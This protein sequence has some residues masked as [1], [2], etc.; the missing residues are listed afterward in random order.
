MARSA[1]ARSQ[2]FL[3]SGTLPTD[4]WA[5]VAAFG[6]YFCMYMFRKPYTAAS[7]ESMRAFE[8]A[9]KPLAIVSQVLGYTISKFVGIRVVAEATPA[10]RIALYLGLIGSAELALVLF[11]IT[12][13][14]WNLIWLFANGLPLGMVFGLVLPFLEGRTRTELLTAGLCASFVLADGVAKSVGVWLMGQGVAET[15]MPATSGLIFVPGILLFGWML[16]K[17]PPPSA[18][19]EQQRGKREPMDKAMRCA[20][21]RKF[22][23]G[24]GLLVAVYS[25]VGVL[26][27]IRGDFGPE[28]WKGLQTKVDPGVFSQTELIV[29][30]CVLLVMAGL[31]FI[32]DNAKAFETGLLLSVG[33]LFLIILSLLGL[34]TGMIAPYAFVVL[35][36]IGLYIPY[37]SFHATV[38]ERLIAF[39][40]ERGTIGYVMYLADSSS[41]AA[42]VVVL[43][44][45]NFGI[46]N[47]EQILPFF[48]NFSWFTAASCLLMLLP[49]WMYFKKR[50]SE[51]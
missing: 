1:G 6:A 21:M 45:K 3:V 32:K 36:G 39:T 28:I 5:I 41:Y 42:L 47:T 7:Y 29:A 34:Q 8:M 31:V 50:K 24:I 33:G 14:P 10:K 19:D 26:R 49:A 46:A 11:G 51:A 43:L 25:L 48:I 35:I 37:I 38:F 40:R 23:L 17:I 44:F 13:A 2:T 18:V 30:L 15:W 27:G 4:I 16:S 22:A 9:F 20:F 12:P